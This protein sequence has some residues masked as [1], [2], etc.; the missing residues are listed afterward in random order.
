MSGENLPNKIT[1]YMPSPIK[2]L[3][4][5]TVEVVQDTFSS[6]HHAEKLIASSIEEQLK[7]QR[8]M[9]HVLGM[10]AC[11]NIKHDEPAED[12]I[13]AFKIALYDLPPD[14]TIHT[15]GFD[16]EQMEL[17]GRHIDIAPLEVE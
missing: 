12:Q 9:V 17:L 1:R 4:E 16:E 5:N 11:H 6:R 7:N 13:L 3:I 2:R 14:M 15:I 8:M 10:T